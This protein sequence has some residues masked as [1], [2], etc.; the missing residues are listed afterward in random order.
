LDI[1]DR[2]AIVVEVRI[3]EDSRELCRGIAVREEALTT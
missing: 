1:P 2:S 3:I